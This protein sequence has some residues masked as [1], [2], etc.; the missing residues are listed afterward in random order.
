MPHTRLFLL[1]LIIVLSSFMVQFRAQYT[2][3]SARIHATNFAARFGLV[4]MDWIARGAEI[5]GT[6]FAP[7]TE[8]DPYP[9]GGS[10]LLVEPLDGPTWLCASVLGTTV[11]SST[12][13]TAF[14][15]WPDTDSS[16]G[17]PGDNIWQGQDLEPLYFATDNLASLRQPAA[18]PL[19]DA[20]LATPLETESQLYVASRWCAGVLSVAKD[21]MKC[22]PHERTHSGTATAGA[23]ITLRGT[24][25]QKGTDYRCPSSAPTHL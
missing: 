21:Q 13:P 16:E 2:G 18:F 4:R 20:T 9:V 25:A 8:N 3:S 12:L 5:S 11:G 14:A 6:L 17:T 24:Y 15:L 1:A 22:A 7:T 10:L 23:L 19:A